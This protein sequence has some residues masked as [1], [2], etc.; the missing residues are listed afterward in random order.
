MKTRHK[1]LFTLIS[2][3]LAGAGLVAI[4]TETHT[5]Y[6]RYQGMRTITG[7]EAIWF[8]QTCLVLASLP[9]VVWVK[10]EWVGISAVGWWIGLMAWI[11]VPMFSR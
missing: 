9:M 10:R 4:A 3:V 2:V 8:G 1:L 6:S 7:E 5:G 11:F